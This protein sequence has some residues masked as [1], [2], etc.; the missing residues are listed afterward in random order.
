MIAAVLDTNVIV[1]AAIG[2]SRASSSRV[3]VAYAHRLFRLAFCQ[4]TLKELREV[5]VHPRI[6]AQHGWTDDELQRYLAFLL[7]NAVYYESIGPVAAPSLT[8]DATDTKFL[9]LA[10]TAGASYLVTNDRRHL[11]PLRQY[12]GT[13]IVSPGEFLKRLP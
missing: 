7:E 5:L 3:L 1:Q 9:D 12:M 4:S 2:S 8:R 13:L 11:L 10:A 6:R